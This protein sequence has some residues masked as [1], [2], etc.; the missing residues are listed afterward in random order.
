MPKF[1]KKPVV[2]EAMRF[3]DEDKDIVKNWITTNGHGGV[4]DAK[5]VLVIHTLEGDMTAQLGDW[6][7]K[8]VNG[9]FYPCKDDIF[10]QTYELV[11][12][13]DGP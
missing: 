1:R 13:D 9:E 12:E 2:I 5:P 4:S 6:V 8:G 10:Q 7:I 3:T 11:W